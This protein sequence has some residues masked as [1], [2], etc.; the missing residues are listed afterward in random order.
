VTSAREVANSG[1]RWLACGAWCA[2]AAVVA[3]AFG[4]HGLSDR[5]DA[6]GLELW[7]TAARYLMYGGLAL[8]LLGLA[9]SRGEPD[10]F[11]HLAGSAVLAGA[12]VF[13]ATVALLALGGPS[14]LGAVTPLGGASMIAGLVLFGARAWSRRTQGPIR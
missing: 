5:L 1:M 2:A 12:V 14:W 11:T 8:G 7:E 13:S 6:R 9:S 3:G 4:A 10:R